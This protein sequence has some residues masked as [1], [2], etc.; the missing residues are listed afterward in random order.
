MDWLGRRKHCLKGPRLVSCVIDSAL[1]IEMGENHVVE[2]IYALYYS[3][4]KGLS[5]N[6][7]KN[8]DTLCKVCFLR[9]GHCY[10]GSLVNMI[11]KTFDNALHLFI[12]ADGNTQ[13]IIDARFR[14]ITHHNV[15]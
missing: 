1:L 15:V 9:G 14:K 3:Y 8:N 11:L 12:G 2:W 7:Q 13:V 4:F 5:E 10:L 6:H